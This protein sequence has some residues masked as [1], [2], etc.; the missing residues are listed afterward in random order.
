MYSGDIRSRINDVMDDIE[1][2]VGDI[3][4]ILSSVENMANTD[5]EILDHHEIECLQQAVIEAME[6]LK[7]LEDALF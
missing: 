1:T 3:R 7:T 6:S 2:R 4:S 5:V